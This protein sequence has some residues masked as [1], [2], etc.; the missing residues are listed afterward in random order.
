M[1]ED[2]SIKYENKFGLV[3]S[4]GKQYIDTT[5]SQKIFEYHVEVCQK[6]H[7]LMEINKH[8]GNLR[9]NFPKGKKPVI[10][11]GHH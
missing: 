4:C 11:L 9:I 6:F 5:T 8:G 10:V 2:D 1:T 3:R 7:E